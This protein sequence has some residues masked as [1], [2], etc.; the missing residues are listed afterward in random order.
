MRN[1]LVASEARLKEIDSQLLLETT[2]KNKKLF[3][4]LSKERALL[5]EILTLYHQYLDSEKNLK[6]ALTMSND[7]DNE[8][9][10]FGKEEHKRL[11][12]L[13]E[14]LTAKLTVLLLPQDPNDDKNVIMEIRG[15][16]GGD[17]GNIFAGDLYRM[18]TRYAEKQ[19][20]KAQVLSINECEVGGVSEVVISIQGDTRI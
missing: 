14:D 7:K 18:Y 8:I 15:A 19:G 9:A 16:A 13:L 11:T 2:I 3:R 17:E 5:E 10:T 4:D 1:R 6:D 20:W 12:K